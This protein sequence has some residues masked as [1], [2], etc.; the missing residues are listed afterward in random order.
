MIMEL[1]SELNLNLPWGTLFIKN[2]N[3][4]DISIRE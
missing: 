3:V 1:N 2:V 4:Y